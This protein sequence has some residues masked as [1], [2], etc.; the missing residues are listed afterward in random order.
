M[1]ERK[2][3][4]DQSGL[5]ERIP[6]TTSTIAL[7]CEF[8]GDRTRKF[9]KE[10]QASIQTV[11]HMREVMSMSATL[12]RQELDFFIIDLRIDRNRED[13][14]IPK[15]QVVDIKHFTEDAM[16]KLID[17]LI[18]LRNEFHFCFMIDSFDSTN[19]RNTDSSEILNKFVNYFIDNGFSHISILEGG[20]RVCFLVF[21][22]VYLTFWGF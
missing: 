12:S 11:G 5:S 15:S 17:D 22:I 9:S 2:S 6:T 16:S 4:Q 14:M 20:F 1:R 3:I 13:G 7:Q 10:L 21:S 18:E 19:M 8:C